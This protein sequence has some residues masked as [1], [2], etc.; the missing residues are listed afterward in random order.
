MSVKT[1]DNV[2]QEGIGLPAYPDAVLVKKGK[3][4]G[5]ADIDLSF[6]N[7]ALRVKALSYHTT[8]TPAQVADFYRKSLGRYGDVIQCS[9]NKP[10]GT[11]VR[12]AEG[13]SCDDE[14]KNQVNVSDDEVSSHIELKAGSKTPPAHRRDRSGRRRHQNRSCRTRP[15]QPRHA[16]WRVERRHPA[17]TALRCRRTGPRLLRLAPHPPLR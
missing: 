5:A 17:I 13:L 11:P 14:K 2:A 12:T 10:V 8:D 7:F 15:S 1:N 9:H 4:N 6:G 3:D 16:R